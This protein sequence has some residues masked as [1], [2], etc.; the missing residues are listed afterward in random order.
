MLSVYCKKDDNKVKLIFSNTSALK[1]D[2]TEQLIETFFRL[3]NSDKFNPQGT[4]IGLSIVRKIIEAHNG[5]IN[6]YSD[7][8]NIFK[9]SIELQSYP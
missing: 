9:I 1:I 5:T 2:N 4:G 6:C 7:R 3:E 8:E